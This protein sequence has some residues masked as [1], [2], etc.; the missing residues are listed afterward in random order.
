MYAC[1]RRPMFLYQK[2]QALTAITRLDIGDTIYKLCEPC[3]EKTTQPT[4]IQNLSMEKVDYRDY[5][6]IKVNDE[7]IDLAYVFVNSEIEN[8]FINLAAIADCPAQRVSPLLPA[9]SIRS[10]TPAESDI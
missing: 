8:N 1:D 9:N 3:G 4:S 10:T 6:Q 2:K 5:W 7:G